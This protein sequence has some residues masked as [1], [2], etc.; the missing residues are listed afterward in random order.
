MSLKH[1]G[2][3][4]FL[5]V[6]TLSSPLK[7]EDK[8]KLA[9]EEAKIEKLLEAV[10][11]SEAVFIRNGEKHPAKKARSHLEFKYNKARN[12]FW[13]FGPKTKI[14]ALEF[15]EKIASKSSTTGEIY[16][17]KPKGSEE[18]IPTETW[19][20]EKLKEIEK[21]QDSKS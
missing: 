2:F 17:I 15:I 7:A 14:T 5:L 21:V 16:K 11:K 8:E 18:P 13:F 1:L 6:L 12:M 20:N 3:S 9:R 4:L 10:G 19:L